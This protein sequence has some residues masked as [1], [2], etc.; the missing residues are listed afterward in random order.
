[1]GQW[2]LNLTPCSS[3]AVPR[4][5]SV[6]TP[7]SN[8]HRSLIPY[9][10]VALL[11]SGSRIL[12]NRWVKKIAS[13]LR[14]LSLFLLTV[15]NHCLFLFFACFPL[16][17]SSPQSWRS[18]YVRDHDL[19]SGDITSICSP[20]P[21]VSWLLVVTSPRCQPIFARV[22]DTNPPL[23][24]WGM[25]SPG[26]QTKPK[27]ESLLHQPGVKADQGNSAIPAASSM[28]VLLTKYEHDR[29]GPSFK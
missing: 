3:V 26:V 24:T 19:Q 20:P 15:V 27:Q 8:T 25:P 5:L 2:I 16:T 4:V 14:C 21:W 23:Y 9:A 1:M 6:H 12:L 10:L 18:L 28:L 7:A 13:L 11:S 17:Y 22:I 29:G